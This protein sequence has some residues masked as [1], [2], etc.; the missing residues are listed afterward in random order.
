MAKKHQVYYI[1]GQKVD[2]VTTILRVIDKPAL[3]EWKARVGAQA[4]KETVT[5]A[6]EFGSIV[7]TAIESICLHNQTP[8]YQDRRVQKVVDNFRQWAENNVEEWVAMEEAAYY[9]DPEAGVQYAGT[10]DAFARLKDGQLALIDFKTSKR[11]V[12]EYYL[13][14]AAYARA[15]WYETPLVKPQDIQQIVIVHLV[16]D[17]LTWEDVR[18]PNTDEY[19]Q[20]FLHA[21]HLYSWWKKSNA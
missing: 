11:I 9:D 15:H 5:K 14:A 18:V 8:E 16:H 6:G 1:R 21:Y 20:L 2:S 13:Q 19:H 7:H 3:D 17:T 4:A 10:V 12:P